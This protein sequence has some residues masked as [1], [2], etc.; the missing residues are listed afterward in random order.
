[1][2][3]PVAGVQLEVEAEDFDAEKAVPLLQ[4]VSLLGDKPSGTLR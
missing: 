3:K 1:M 2:R 4:A